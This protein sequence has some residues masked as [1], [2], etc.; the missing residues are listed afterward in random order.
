ML[1]WDQDRL[2]PCP[3]PHQASGAS[4]L[5]D[6]AL[7]RVYAPPPGRRWLR[8]NMVSSLDGAAADS[9]G[10]SGGINTPADH[11]VFGLLR[12]LA[13]VVLV[14]A[15]TVRA[16]GYRRLRLE[17]RWQ[18]LRRELKLD[19]PP[20]L[21]VLS[22]SADIPPALLRAEQG[23]SD[24]VIVA[25]PASPEHRRTQLV[26]RLGSEAVIQLAADSAQ[27]GA[28]PTVRSVLDA[29]AERGWTNVL[30]EGGPSLLGAAL[31]E[32]VLDELCLTVSP[33]LVGGAGRRIVDTPDICASARLLAL[34]EQDGTLMGRWATR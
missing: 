26:R 23:D 19:G 13:Q 32:G 11:V 34:V 20:V 6:A 15:G 25:G 9:T 16:E 21:V 30:C 24:V 29:L 12:A 17:P 31:S 3:S 18:A 14:G 22:A 2:G 28:H 27:P 8:A 7:A 1:C 33:L 10:V 4:G 5:D